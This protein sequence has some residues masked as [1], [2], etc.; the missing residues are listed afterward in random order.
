M[1]FTIEKF[2][3][4]LGKE[5]S[6]LL[7]DAPFRSWTFKKSV[8]TDLEKPRIDYI[9]AQDGF[10]FVCDEADKVTCIFLYFDRSRSFRGSIQG[11]P[12]ISSRQEVIAHLGS[13]SESGGG[14]ND[15]ILGE[16][17]A[18]DRFARPGCV[19]HVEYRHDADVIN[20]ITLMR[21]D[22]AP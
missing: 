21:A 17:G 10:D 15:P 3:N 8:E 1:N 13:P 14:I 16:Y 20:K 6:S 7:G 18:W 5:D 11:L 4:Y 9:F 12:S 22:V 2:S 19:I